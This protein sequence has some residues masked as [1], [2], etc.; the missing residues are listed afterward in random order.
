MPYDKV[1]QAKT[2]QLLEQHFDVLEYA[3]KEI[4]Q[5]LDRER[6]SGESAFEV[7]KKVI[8]KEGIKEGFTLLTQRLNK[9]VS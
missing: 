3:I 7:A 2:R 9:Y 4:T 5:E 8:R 6:I 1:L